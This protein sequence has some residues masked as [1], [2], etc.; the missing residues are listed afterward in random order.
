MITKQLRLNSHNGFV[1]SSFFK[2]KFSRR[3]S[4]G[5]GKIVLSF[6]KQTIQAMKFWNVS[7]SLKK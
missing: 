2:F 4:I 5:S 6:S 3:E 7:K 1:L